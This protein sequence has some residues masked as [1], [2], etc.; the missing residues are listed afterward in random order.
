MHLH[1]L[2]AGLLHT[3]LVVGRWQGSWRNVDV[4]LLL[5]LLFLNQFIVHALQ[6]KSVSHQRSVTARI[7]PAYD[8]ATHNDSDDDDDDH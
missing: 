2:V 5:L 3:R 6:V 7:T 1:A 8:V 4:L